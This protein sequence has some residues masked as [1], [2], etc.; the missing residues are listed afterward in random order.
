MDHSKSSW[1]QPHLSLA[2]SD[3]ENDLREDALRNPGAP[4]CRPEHIL[5]D[6]KATITTMFCQFLGL[7]QHFKVFG[8]YARTPSDLTTLIFVHKMRMDPSAFTVVLDAFVLE[9]SNYILP[10]INMALQ[11]TIS[12][13]QCS[14]EELNLWGMLLPALVERSRHGWHHR[15][16]CE[17]IW[18]GNVLTTKGIEEEKLCRC[19]KGKN[20]DGF[21]EVKGWSH[22]A[23]SVTRIAISPL[24]AVSYLE[25]IGRNFANLIGGVGQGTS[26]VVRT[27]KHLQATLEQRPA[28]N[29]SMEELKKAILKQSG[30]QSPRQTETNVCIVCSARGQ[31]RLSQCSRCKKVKYCSDKCQRE[32][33]KTHKPHC[34]T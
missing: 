4:K 11:S 19:G 31:P 20:V 10:H 22:L 14:S 8:L 5:T 34:S 26:Q 29:N 33:W 9:R 1:V 2:S 12:K 28:L 13:I 18:N 32:D 6:I 21:R 23:T 27:W 7:G 25:E 15:S 24:F 30:G 3:R 16:E 17:Y